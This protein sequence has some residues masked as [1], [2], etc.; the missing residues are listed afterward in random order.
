MVARYCKPAML[1]VFLVACLTGCPSDDIGATISVAGK[2]TIDDKPLENG[3][4]AFFPIESKG[5]KTKAGVSGIVKS[6]EYTVSSGTAS[7]NRSGAP[8]GWYK[9]T[10]VPS[11][12]MG[13]MTTEVTKEK[14]DLKL[15]GGS[16]ATP[17]AEKF[18][19]AE[20]TPLEVEVKSGGNYDLKATTK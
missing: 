16:K 13:P 12:G 18:K 5:N 6:G 7:A 15:G 17:I 10:I 19:N 11:A 4:V 14:A 8:P 2:V 20:T 1:A 9:V 3:G